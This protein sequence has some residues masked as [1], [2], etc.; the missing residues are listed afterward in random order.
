VRAADGAFVELSLAGTERLVE[1][2]CS[3]IDSRRRYPLEIGK[4][5]LRV[6][7]DCFREPLVG[8]SGFDRPNQFRTFQR[9]R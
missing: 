9:T 3:G 1:D 6:T 4:L 7:R 8:E 5:Y 2:Y